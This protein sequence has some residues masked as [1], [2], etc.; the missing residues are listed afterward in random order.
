MLMLQQA[1]CKRC[2]DKRRREVQCCKTLAFRSPRRALQRSDQT[3][4]R[5]DVLAKK[6]H[7]IALSGAWTRIKRASACAESS[8]SYCSLERV[9]TGSTNKEAAAVLGNSAALAVVVRQGYELI[10]FRSPVALL[11]VVL[12]IATAQAAPVKRFT[13]VKQ[14]QPQVV[15]VTIPPEAPAASDLETPSPTATQPPSPTAAPSSADHE[16]KS[17]YGKKQASQS[18]PS[19]LPTQRPMPQPQPQPQSQPIIVVIQKPAPTPVPA[20]ATAQPS[21]VSPAEA[22]A[23][24]KKAPITKLRTKPQ[25]ITLPKFSLL[26][27]LLKGKHKG[28]Q[29]EASEKSHEKS[30]AESTTQ[31]HQRRQHEEV[32]QE[33]PLPDVVYDV[34]YA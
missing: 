19:V 18:A 14:A 5:L 28:N 1:Q 8:R 9:K 16:K 27:S 13:S 23:A 4:Q 15:V 26:P 17:D 31:P 7:C 10:M 32:I 2:H 3:Q 22:P 30:S 21:Q 24:Q 6:R 33:K 12:V 29:E 11:A 25:Q 20:P 34:D